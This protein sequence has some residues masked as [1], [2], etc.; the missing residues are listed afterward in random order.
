MWFCTIKNTSSTKKAEITWQMNDFKKKLIT[1]L[2]AMG[3]RT[4]GGWLSLKKH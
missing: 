1:A 3:V 2:V 4:T